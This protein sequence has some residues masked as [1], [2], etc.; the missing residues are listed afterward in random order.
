[1]DI[2][3]PSMSAFISVMSLGFWI[4]LMPIEGKLVRI[5]SIRYLEHSPA[6]NARLNKLSNMNNSE[7][8]SEQNRCHELSSQ[9]SNQLFLLIIS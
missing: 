2:P 5:N 1:M 6:S 7:Q 3:G 4:S 8:V 9:A